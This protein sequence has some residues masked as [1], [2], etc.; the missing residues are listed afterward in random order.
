MMSSEARVP[1]AEVTRIIQAPADQVF[2]AWLDRTA[3]L[4]FICPAPGRAAEVAIDPQVGGAFRFRMALPDRELV[5]TGEYIAID[6]PD[7]LS[8]TWRC[9]DTGDLQ[10]VVTVTLTPRDGD[11]T[12]MT[13]TH[14]MLPG[15]LIRQHR[16]GWAL[17]AAQLDGHARSINRRH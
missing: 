13:I 4:D 2:D 8:F 11:K 5:V 14:S 1:S 9:S 3:L 7:R 12:V 16:E 6:R 15:D 17:T 10:S